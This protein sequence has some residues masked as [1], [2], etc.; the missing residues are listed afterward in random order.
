MNEVNILVVDDNR[1]NLRLLSDVL[2]AQ[3]Y[4]V[5]PT[6]KG[7]RAISAAQTKPP[8]L[9]LL[10]ILMP[11]MDGYT[12]WKVIMSCPHIQYMS[13]I[14]L[15]SGDLIRLDMI[16]PPQRNVSQNVVR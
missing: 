13:S 2:T 1:D 15:A 5:R 11:E 4:R 14:M 3:G 6:S 10:D 9:I 8:D 7:R 16:F 12:T